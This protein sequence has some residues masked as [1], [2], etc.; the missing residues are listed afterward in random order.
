MNLCYSFSEPID[1]HLWKPFWTLENFTGDLSSFNCF[2][3]KLRWF[4]GPVTSGQKPLKRWRFWISCVTR[5]TGMCIRPH[6]LCMLATRVYRCPDA[7]CLERHSQSKRGNL[8]WDVKHPTYLSRQSIPNNWLIPVKS[9]FF[10]PKCEK[11]VLKPP[12]GTREML[13]LRCCIPK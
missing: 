6:M 2:W 13:L 12:C 4:P 11:L 3:R 1:S 7:P 8:P 5:F 9:S 10:L